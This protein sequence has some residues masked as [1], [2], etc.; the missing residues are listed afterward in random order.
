VL[1]GALTSLYSFTPVTLAPTA[2]T[3]EMQFPIT[4][5]RGAN[6]SDPQFITLQ[7]SYNNG[8]P[9]TK[10]LVIAVAQQKKDASDGEDS[11]FSR[12]TFLNAYNFDFYGKLNSNY[13]GVFNIYEPAR[14]RGTRKKNST[15]NRVKIGLNAGI[16][17]IN[18]GLGDSSKIDRYQYENSLIRPL[19]SIIPGKR[20]LRQFNKYTSATTNSAWSFY[21]QPLFM[22]NPTE[23]AATRVYLHGHFELFVNKVTTKTTRTVVQQDTATFSNPI[24]NGIVVRVPTTDEVTTTQTFYNGYFGAGFT[25]DIKLTNSASSSLFLQATAGITSNTP[26]IGSV[27][28]FDIRT[29]KKNNWHGFYLVRAAFNQRLSDATKIVIAQDIRGL[30]PQYSPLYATFIGLNVKVDELLKLI[31]G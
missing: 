31:K 18:Y 2:S 1:P 7:M 14:Y 9:V 15:K 26:N 28:N 27:A 30:F 22:L 4:I 16:M 3:S 24:P 8:V 20:Y 17:K 6:D 21:A 10:N 12:L 25:F 19:D 11:F 13:V 5:R 23:R 29:P